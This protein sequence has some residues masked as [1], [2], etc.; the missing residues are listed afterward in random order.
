[1]EAA[2]D[3]ARRPAVRQRAVSSRG[4]PA[5]G[6]G[7]AR[8]DRWVHHGARFLCVQPTLARSAEFSPGGVRVRS[9]SLASRAAIG[10]TGILKHTDNAIVRMAANHQDEMQNERRRGPGKADPGGRAS[11]NQGKAAKLIAW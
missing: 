11:K 9:R 3:L 6:S 4:L 2:L 5:A 1:M 7:T 8:Q 10:E